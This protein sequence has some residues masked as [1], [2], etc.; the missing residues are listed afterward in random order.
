MSLVQS[1]TNL[2]ASLEN[3]Q[4]CELAQG[5]RHLVFGRGS[6][7]A[8]LMLIGEGPG[9]DEDRLGQP[10]VGRAGQLLDKILAAAELPGDDTYICN[11]VKCRPPD[12]RLPNAAEVEACKPHLREQIRLIRPQ[13]I[14]CLGALASQVLIGPQARITRDRGRWLQKGRM[15]IMPTFHPAA[16]LRDESKKRPVWEDMQAV[17]D[18]YQALLRQE[19]GEPAGKTWPP[20]D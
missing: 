4:G 14:V 1:L 5:R 11:V 19:A 3:C 17:R 15:L 20:T 13:L 12:N 8:R 16:L 6:P 7:R 9:A 10:F 18:Q 2:A